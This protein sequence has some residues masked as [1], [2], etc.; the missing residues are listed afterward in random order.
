MS[1]SALLF[2]VRS[3]FE[4]N[5]YVREIQNKTFGFADF[6]PKAK[7]VKKYRFLKKIG[8]VYQHILPEFNSLK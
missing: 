5:T 1:V 8:F 7:S 2:Y 4:R 3:L 6:V